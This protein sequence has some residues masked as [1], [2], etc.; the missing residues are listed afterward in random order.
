[1]S[2]VVLCPRQ[3]SGLCAQGLAHRVL[4]QLGVLGERASRRPVVG[5]ALGTSGGRRVPRTSAK[6]K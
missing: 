6:L 3:P 5:A 1:M 2:T 4:S